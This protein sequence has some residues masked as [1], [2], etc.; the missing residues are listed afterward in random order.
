VK[1]FW[2]DSAVEQESG[3]FTVLLDRRSIRT[4]KGRPLL[5][6]TEAMAQAVAAEWGAVEDEVQPL[7]MPITGL[8]NAAIDIVADDPAGFAWSLARYGESDLLCYRAEGP[9]PLVE[10]QAAAW[11][12]ILGWAEV[13]LDCHFETTQGLMHVRQPDAG[14]TSLAM[15]MAGFCPFRLAALST[16]VTL[17]GS[18]V[19]ALA[20]T[21][22]AVDADAAWDAAMVDEV[23]QAE[24]WGE[25]REAL[26]QR[27]G[28][29]RQFLE[30]ARFLRLA[31][32]N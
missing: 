4:P 32:E 31:A 5:L 29:R 3:G 1:R 6:P 7:S 16:L 27:E 12:P 11:N 17:S 8:A 26:A 28:R 14:I 23:W 25:D 13:R 21:E 30:S 18:A 20:V 10:R 22:G 15:A 19:L 2:T 9:A 24:Q